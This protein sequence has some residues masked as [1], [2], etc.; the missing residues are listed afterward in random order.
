MAVYMPNEMDFQGKNFSMIISGSPG[1]GKTT[2]ALSAPDPVLVDFDE[3]VSRVKARHRKPTIMGKTYEEI[4]D[5]IETSQLVKDAKTIVIDTGGAFITYLQDWAIRDN[6]TV[7]KQ[8]SSNAISQ[9][10]FGAVKAEFVRFTNVLRTVMKKNMIYIFHTVEEK[11]GDVTKYRLM[12]EGSARNIVWQP[13]DLGCYMMITGNKRYL[14]FTPTEQYFAKGCYGISGLVEVPELTESTPN[15]L[16]THLFQ[17]ARENIVREASEG[18]ENQAKYEA[19]MEQVKQIVAGVED[20]G[21]AGAAAEG[22][23]KLEHALSSEREARAMLSARTKDL[24]LK[25]D[26]AAKAYVEEA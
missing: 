13:C 4:R 26:K 5:D 3:G 18:A 21:S 7:N 10:G 17:K 8:K 24:G 25:W 19:A 14:G 1:I 23:K 6:S 11:D 16:I 2:L 9:K 12:C 22:L 20:A 15:D